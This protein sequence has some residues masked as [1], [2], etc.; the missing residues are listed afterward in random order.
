[1]LV[2]YTRVSF[3]FTSCL[4]LNVTP[5]SEK[6]WNS[7]FKTYEF[8]DKITAMLRV[9][10][11]LEDSFGPEPKRTDSD[12]LSDG[13]NLVHRGNTGIH[14]S[15]C[16]SSRISQEYSISIKKKKKNVCEVK[17]YCTAFDSFSWMCWKCISGLSPYGGWLRFCFRWGNLLICSWYQVCAG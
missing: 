6:Q 8:L 2:L 12:I 4:S 3:R 14:F 11:L 13:A 9:E 17:S 10:Y 16:K 15:F 5:A 7:S 1:M